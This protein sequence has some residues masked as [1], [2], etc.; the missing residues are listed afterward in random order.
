M[1]NKSKNML[2]TWDQCTIHKTFIMSNGNNSQQAYMLK[3]LYRHSLIFITPS[4]KEGKYSYH[5][6]TD[7]TRKERH[8]LMKTLQ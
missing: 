8:S 2:A 1:I 3:T 4:R 5:Q 7:S 6:L